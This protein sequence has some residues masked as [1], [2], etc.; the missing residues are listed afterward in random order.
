MKESDHLY[1]EATRRLLYAAFILLAAA[2][3]T[4]LALSP[5][6]LT[7]LEKAV[8]GEV[9]TWAPERFSDRLVLYAVYFI[10]LVVPI[11]LVYILPTLYREN[12]AVA[13][14]TVFILVLLILEIIGVLRA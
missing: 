1:A 7:Q 14:L 9:S 6:A 10:N 12:K 11:G 5:D 3:V 4:H 2:L 8:R 13:T